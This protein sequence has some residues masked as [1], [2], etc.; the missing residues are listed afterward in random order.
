MGNSADDTGIGRS[1]VSSWYGKRVLGIPSIV[2]GYAS[3]GL[4][5]QVGGPVG[6]TLQ[7]R[8]LRE[9]GETL[10]QAMSLRGMTH[11]RLGEELGVTQ[12]AISAW[13]SG[14]AEPSSRTVFSIERALE[15]PPG[16]LSRTLGYLPVDG[17]QSEIVSFEQVVVGDPLLAED[18]KRGLIALYRSFV[19]QPGASEA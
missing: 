16:H 17:R 19:K 5:T 9:F 3:G 1:R 6:M 18:Q 10:A 15:L 7:S 12:S 8:R 11:R 14:A 2:S 13:K 4:R